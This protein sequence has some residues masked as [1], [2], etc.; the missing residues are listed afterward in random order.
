[1]AFN[2]DEHKRKWNQQRSRKVVDL[3][4]R[5]KRTKGCACCGFNKHHAG[6]VLDHLDQTTKSRTTGRNR[7]YNPLWSRERLKDELAKC[8]VLC[9]TCHYI[10]TYENEHYK[11]RG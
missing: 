9:A 3:V 10:H 4:N 6:L 11:F 5:W 7:A 1:M 8:R 2:R